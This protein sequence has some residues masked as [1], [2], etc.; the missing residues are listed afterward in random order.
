MCFVQLHFSRN[1]YIN[2]HTEE[3]FNQ[4]LGHT[5]HP[6]VCFYG[7]CNVPV[8]HVCVT[9]Q[10][11]LF[12]QRKFCDKVSADPNSQLDLQTHTFPAVMPL[13]SSLS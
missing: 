6:I 7:Q 3:I 10:L 4:S 2:L 9:A 13:K 12:C 1:I 11:L 8:W 5:F